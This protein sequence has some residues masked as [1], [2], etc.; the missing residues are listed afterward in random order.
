[1]TAAMLTDKTKNNIW[2]GGLG[3]GNYTT[4]DNPLLRW[5]SL[6]IANDFKK[7]WTK[8]YIG[9]HLYRNIETLFT[10]LFQMVA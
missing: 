1:M 2:S 7:C 5:S 4:A 9:M 3:V 8:Y 10:Q 6:C